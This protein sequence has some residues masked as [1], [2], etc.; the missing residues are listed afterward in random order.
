MLQNESDMRYDHER[1]YL[2]H[3]FVFNPTV[4]SCARDP[5]VCGAGDHSKCMSPV[6]DPT[7]LCKGL[8]VRVWIGSVGSKGAAVN[9][10]GNVFLIIGE[11]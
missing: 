2:I 4:T 1:L 7:R 10:H 6:T 9:L 3:F 8:P 5:E 11:F